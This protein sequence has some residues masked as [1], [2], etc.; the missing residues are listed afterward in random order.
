MDKINILDEINSGSL[1]LDE[2]YDKFDEILESPK[3]ENISE[4]LGL[5]IPEYSAYAQGLGLDDLAKIRK[6][7]WPNICKVC[8]KIINIETGGWFAKL[9][10]QE[11]VYLTHI[12][13]L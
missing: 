11:K 13:C 7:G 10:E 4:H 3:I 9:D 8:G 6:S 1:S 12:D 5:S 2:A